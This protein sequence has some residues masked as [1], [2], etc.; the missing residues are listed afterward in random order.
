[1]AAALV[2]HPQPLGL[3]A[4]WNVGTG[5]EADPAARTVRAHRLSGGYV[6]ATLRARAL[7]RAVTPYARAQRYDGGKK[8]ETDARRHRV[9]EVEVG[10]EW[11]ATPEVE[12]T[13]AFAAAERETSD[14]ATPDN[15]QRGR[16]VRVQAQVAF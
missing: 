16:R 14:L 2:L 10:A 15:R 1:M 12:L 6:Q 9:R 3:Q 8:F 7:G 13:A 11:L 4:E 5:P